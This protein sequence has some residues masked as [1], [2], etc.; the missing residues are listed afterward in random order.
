VELPD[1]VVR[2]PDPGREVLEALVIE[3]YRTGALSNFQAGQLLGLSRLEVDAFLKER[4]IQEHACGV[5][6]LDRDLDDLRTFE[7]RQIGTSFVTAVVSD[8]SPLN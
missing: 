5:D 4:G 6:D 8:T 3:G 2:H 7:A 1:D